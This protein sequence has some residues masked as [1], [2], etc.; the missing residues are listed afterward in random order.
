MD[1]LQA[2]GVVLILLVVLYIICG[3]RLSPV[4]G[5]LWSPPFLGENIE[6][7]T[8]ISP[9]SFYFKRQVSIN[10]YISHALAIIPLPANN[11][12][13]KYV[14]N[15]NPG[16]LIRCYLFGQEIVMVGD[17]DHWKSLNAL[18]PQS[19][20]WGL[21]FEAINQLVNLRSSSEPELHQFFRKHMTASLS[22]TN[23][24]STFIPRIPPIFERHV[25]LWFKDDA[26]LEIDSLI[27]R[28]VM[29][30]A[31]R[32]VAGF[33]D[34]PEDQLKLISEVAIEVQDGLFSP[35]VNLP[36][37]TFYKSL[38]R[39]P[40]YLSLLESCLRSRFPVDPETGALV[41]PPG[42]TSINDTTLAT[43]LEFKDRNELPLPSL[44]ADRVI[45]NVVAA[46][47]TTGGALLVTLVG[48]SLVPGLIDKLRV[49]QAR[50]IS[51]HG[52]ELSWDILQQN[53]PLLDAAAKEA[54]RL[55]PFALLIGRKVKEDGFQLGGIPI[56]K[57]TSL[58]APSSVFHSFFLEDSNN[59]GKDGLPSYMDHNNI[60]R[61]FKTERWEGESKPI[62]STFG[63]GKHMCLGMNVAMSEIKVCLALMLRKGS[64]ECMN[65]DTSFAYLPKPGLR[66]G[67]TRI[68]FT[69]APIPK[70]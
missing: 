35:P 31:L 22:L 34:L 1:L 21:P 67:P 53:V 41:Y 42:S 17:Y 15:N 52:E 10:Y 36:G 62:I 3:I 20:K 30:V 23:L 7:L 66:E 5:P 6:F 18:E 4:P 59:E 51:Q 40:R 45:S 70:I 68:K 47:D 58:I 44:I 57:G 49:E 63:Q 55:L 60:P 37:F 27:R 54:S 64:W 13:K 25:S 69:K 26:V 61:S 48:I 56:K 28:S 46:S 33:N 65:K 8:T 29:E 16:K 39:R 9:A 50:L 43:L 14:H 11:R 19:I 2:I 12:F 38:Q 24:R 32:V